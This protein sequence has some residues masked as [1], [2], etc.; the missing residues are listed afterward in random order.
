MSY[1]VVY[2][3]LES[4][5]GAEVGV[6]GLLLGTLIGIFFLL[7][8]IK[9]QRRFGIIFSII[10]LTGWIFLGSVGF[11][12]IYYQHSQCMQWARSGDYQMVEGPIVNFKEYT[13]GEGERFSVGN[14]HFEYSSYDLSVCGF[15][16]FGN[17][18]NPIQDGLQVRIAYRDGKI[19]KLEIAKDP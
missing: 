15:K 10:W 12:N 3:I 11:G 16:H 2:D 1:V 8:D 13:R 14:V 4:R 19:L 9:R 6:V 18:G 5:S 7:R 17:K